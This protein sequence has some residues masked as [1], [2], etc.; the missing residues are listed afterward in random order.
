MNKKKLNDA[1]DPKYD[2]LD[3]K[4]YNAFIDLGWLIPQSEE[5]IERAE[6]SLEDL[7]RPT[8]PTELLDSSNILENIRTILGREHKPDEEET[9][10]I[11]PFLG[12]VSDETGLPPSK[13][14][15]EINCPTAFL[16][17]VT[18]NPSEVRQPVREEIIERT[19]RKFPTL[20]R[21]MLRQ[22]LKQSS[23]KIAAAR[24]T[25]YVKEKITF[26]KI[27][28]TSGI[29]GD[30]KIFWLELNKGKDENS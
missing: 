30:E 28:D 4:I 9:F 22:S 1:E 15:Q 2:E 20:K 23:Q 12:Y 8:L 17:Q 11:K 5:D 27:L 10:N 19:V 21:P 24:K 6:K 26:E 7:I 18:E 16:V 13:I 25:S 14:E 3:I 29:V